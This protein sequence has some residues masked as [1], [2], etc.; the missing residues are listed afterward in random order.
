[1]DLV[2]STRRMNKRDRW[3]PLVFF[4]NNKLDLSHLEFKIWIFST[5]DWFQRTMIFFSS[6]WLTITW[7]IFLFALL[8]VNHIRDSTDVRNLSLSCWRCVPARRLQCCG[9]GECL[10]NKFITPIFQFNKIEF[11][12]RIHTR[13]SFKNVSKIVY[14]NICAPI[15]SYTSFYGILTLKSILMSKIKGISCCSCKYHPIII[16]KLEQRRKVWQIINK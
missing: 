1:M 6:S 2:S 13:S 7:L 16:Y 14:Q 10:K 5:N 8:S 12:D 3:L 15:V 4:L 9:F 11:V